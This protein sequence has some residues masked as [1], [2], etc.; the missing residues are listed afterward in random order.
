MI[1]SYLV[2]YRFTSASLAADFVTC[3]T[4]QNEDDND[5]DDDYDDDDD[6]DHDTRH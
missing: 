1:L 4:K 5:G 3:F 6:D 2:N